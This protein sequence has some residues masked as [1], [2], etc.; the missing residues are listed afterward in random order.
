MKT[1]AIVGGSV[2]GI[3]SA[4]AL[5]AA[6]FDGRLVLVGDDVH[7]PYDRPP[8]SKAFLDG[9]VDED[10]IGLLDPADEDE[11]ALEL[12]L[13][14]TASRLDAAGG[15]SCSR[16]APRSAPT[17][18]CSP[19]A[20]GPAGCRAPRAS[21]A[22]TSCGPSTTPSRSGGPCA[23][24]RRASRSSG[25]GFIGAEVASTCRA[26]GLAVTVLDGLPPP[27]GARARPPHRPQLRRPARRARHV[28][29]AG[30]ACRGSRDG[31]ERRGPRRVVGVE[32]GDGTTVQADIVIVGIGIVPNTAWLEG[33]GVTLDRGVRTDAG[34]VTDLPTS[35]PSATSPAG[36]TG[37]RRPQRHEHWTSAGEQAA[38]AAAN[39]LGSGPAAR[40]SGP[41]ATSGPSSTGGCCSSP[42]TRRRTT[43]RDR[44]RRRRRRPVRRALRRRRRDDDRRLRDGQ[45]AGVRPLPPHRAPA[46]GRGRLRRHRTRALQGHAVG[47]QRGG[48]G[49][50]ALEVSGAAPASGWPADSRRNAR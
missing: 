1:I 36:R 12:R 20:A 7:R 32:L 28:A 23:T 40:P 44:R 13:G 14:V 35:W 26:M 43:G 15:A 22:C 38:V 47:R 18:S 45:P 2:A 34:L 31:P 3:R 48:G 50:S 37:R 49:S 21:R 9:S 27:P 33:S 5:R 17:A 25:A 6:G 24:A 29:A 11:L 8:L 16:T 10:A 42:G 41:A 19:P 30:T 39:L 46:P 4:E